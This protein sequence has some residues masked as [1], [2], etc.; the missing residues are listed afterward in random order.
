MKRLK[1][2]GLL[3]ILALIMQM[4]PVAA[5]A[6]VTSD[7]PK[8]PSTIAVGDWYIVEFVKPP[9]AIQA[10]TGNQIDY[11]TA[12]G[13]L[14]VNSQASQA[15]I[16]DLTIEQA[17][18]TTALEST[19]PGAQVSRGYQVVLNAVAVHIPN[20]DL[21]TL[22][23]LASLPEVNR[24]SP[25]QIYTIT[26]DYSLPLIKTSELWSQLGGRVNAGKG[27]KVADIDTGIDPTHAM[28]SGAGWS[29]PS[30]G[31]WPKGYCAEVSGFCNGKIISAR[32]YPPTS[33]VH[34]VEK[35]SPRDS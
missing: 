13:K 17:A 34:V 11:L 35:L 18:F 28:F 1:W 25:Q 26:L 7:S 4:L 24:N 19:I 23:K 8:T 9:L 10:Q 16:N 2:F 21:A 20:S 15:Y 14:D 5:Q 30:T 29:Y 6:L 3:L 27:I 32:F 12:G 33:D 22:Q 31:T